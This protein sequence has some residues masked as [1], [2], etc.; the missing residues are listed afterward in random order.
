M[1]LL[2][3]LCIAALSL[4]WIAPEL[5]GQDWSNRWYFGFGGSAQRL[6]KSVNDSRVVVEETSDSIRYTISSAALGY[7]AQGFLGYRFSNRAGLTLTLGYSGLPFSLS[8]NNLGL[9]RTFSLKSN[10]LYSDLLFDVVLAKQGIFYP[11]VHAGF[12]GGV[13]SFGGGSSKHFTESH[14]TG[15][16]GVR[17]LLNPQMALEMS[18]AYNRTNNDVLDVIG[19]GGRDAYVN[20]RIGLSF[21]T[22][23]LREPRP[24]E[25]S[26][27]SAGGAFASLDAGID[28][29]RK[30]VTSVASTSSFTREYQR[31]REHFMAKH[32]RVALQIFSS[33]ASSY[34]SH[35]LAVNCYY[36]SGQCYYALGDYAAAITEHSKVLSLTSSLKKDGAL[37][38][39]AKCHIQLKEFLEARQYLEQLVAE[40]PAGKAARSAR[41]LLPKLPS[42]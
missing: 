4:G 14:L 23:A 6:V 39:I 26:Q 36:W 1:R 2:T 37:L 21:F 38:M 35:P 13:F 19:T 30:S 28:D 10:L 40:Y 24:L 22:R 11:F 8:Q 7:G 20:F 5:H 18:G 16:L 41:T 3:G 25:F 33:L 34:P 29:S 32:Y 9:L 17:M 12:G 15:G 27:R 42:R 31:G